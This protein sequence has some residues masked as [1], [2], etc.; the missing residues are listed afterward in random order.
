M[1]QKLKELIL[2]NQQATEQVLKALLHQAFETAGVAAQAG[3]V[4]QKKTA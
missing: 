4:R 1:C 3:E 2:A